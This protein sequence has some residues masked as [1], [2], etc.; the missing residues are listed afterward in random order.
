M[1]EALKISGFRKYDDL[2]ID[3]FNK[4]NF[5]LGPNNVGK[6]SVL[7]AIF[8]WACGQNVIPFLNVPLARGRYSGIQN[9]YWIMEEILAS[10]KTRKNIPLHMSFCGTEDSKEIKFDHTIYPS[11]LLTDYDAS[12]KNNLEKVIPRTNDALSTDNPSLI[13]G[14]PGMVQFKSTVIARWEVLN[15]KKKTQI[16][17]MIPQSQI[18][19]IKPYKQAKY[20]DVLS[21]TAVSE[22]VHMYA[23]L[24]RENLL[25]EVVK[26]IK[27]V[28]P[29]IEGFDMIPYPDGSQAPVSVIKKDGTML[30]L[31]SY[32]DGIQKWFY[33]MGAIAVYKNSIICIDEIDSGFH[34]LAQV[35]FSLN[36]IRAA[37][38]NGVQ[39]FVTT[40][41]LEFVDN[42]L[43]AVLMGNKDII[44]SISIIS[45]KDSNGNVKVRKMDAKEAYESR[46]SFNLELR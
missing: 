15:N 31:Y 28:F 29:E 46:K 1:L 16:D 23:S 10:V 13:V 14:I 39:L 11:E 41:N 17:I 22:N 30:P 6:T 36:M 26:E 45:L 35:D 24:K 12:Y 34:P 9:P 25:N 21:H 2:K 32:G 40:H 20:I 37:V 43:E 8:A 33:V 5:I 4:I 19:G 18:N 44:D 7:E 38:E 3:N 27:K 42:M